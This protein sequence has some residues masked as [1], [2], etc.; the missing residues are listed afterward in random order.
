MQSHM[1]LRRRRICL[2]HSFRDVAAAGRQLQG[3]TVPRCAQGKGRS[4]Q[5][6]TTS[7]PTMLH[8]AV[9]R[10]D[11]ASIGSNVRT[12]GS[13]PPGWS[14]AGQIAARQRLRQYHCGS[15][16]DAYSTACSGSSAASR[17]PRGQARSE[18]NAHTRPALRARKVL[19]GKLCPAR[20]AIPDLHPL[21]SA[22]VI[23]QKATPVNTTW[24]PKQLK[25][26]NLVSG[27]HAKLS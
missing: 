26:R 7:F 3:A 12:A 23:L 25:R 10:R 1:L 13:H 15:A 21:T 27:Q 9:R 14:G 4:P 16:W 24:T 2:W 20:E 11:G 19:R 6:C 8:Y 22:S 17:S 18:I 5:V